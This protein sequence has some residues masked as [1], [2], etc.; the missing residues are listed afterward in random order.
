M[1]VKQMGIRGVYVFKI[2]NMKLPIDAGLI[3]SNVYHITVK[4][5]PRKHIYTGNMKKK[6]VSE[7]ILKLGL[8]WKTRTY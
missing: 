7:D 3:Q 2:T 8:L 4:R 5:E 1:M 6:W